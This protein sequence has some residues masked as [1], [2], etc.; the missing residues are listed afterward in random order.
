ME[1][2]RGASVAPRARFSELASIGSRFAGQGPAF[3]NLSDEFAIHFLR[4]VT[5]SDPAI[6]LPTQRP[7]L[8]TRTVPSETRAP[9]DPDELD[10]A[11]LQSYP[12]LVLGRSP[13]NSRP[14]ADYRLA[15]GGRYYEV[16]RRAAT[17]QVLEH[18]PLGGPLDPA[19]VPR[20]AAVTAL[21][22][23]AAREHARL[24]YATG[25]PLSV[26]VPT[27]VQRPVNWGE[28]GGEPYG[29]I[30]RHEAG[31]IVGTL[32][33]PTSGRYQVWLEG[34]FSRKVEVW[35]DGR[36]LGSESYELGPAGQGAVVGNLALRAGA[37]RISIV[38]PGDSAAAGVN[39]INQ[40]VGVLVLS[41]S[42]E[43]EP[44]GEVA[45]AAARSLC[46][47]SLDWIEIVR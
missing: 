29:L 41:P 3:Y 37:H 13:L 40:T 5:P 46:G 44:V 1:A 8:P 10:E 19:A 33:V 27:Q 28:I 24:A 30:P 31:A 20:C 15:Y 16:W 21:A 43:V 6:A 2:Y 36:E 23:R 47:R 18:I 12:L 34:S 14:P 32:N 22:A 25:A 26:L 38:V 39:L 45:P 4:S 42:P 17:P 35:I 7:G 9:W 11:Y